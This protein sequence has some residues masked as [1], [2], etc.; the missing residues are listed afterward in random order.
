MLLVTA[1]YLAPA[2]RP[3][4]QHLNKQTAE[5][6]SL[7]FFDVIVITLIT[8]VSG[9]MAALVVIVTA[10][11]MIVSNYLYFHYRFR[12]VSGKLY[13]CTKQKVILGRGLSF[14]TG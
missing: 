8:V 13:S 6:L 5:L 4:S 2:I 3:S 9:M 14:T 11:V 10:A 12:P 1:L 7:L